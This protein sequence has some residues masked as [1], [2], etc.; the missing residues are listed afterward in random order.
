V[1]TI[2]QAEGIDHGTPK[3]YRQHIR[4]KVMP[5]CPPC[6]EAHTVQQG[7]GRPAVEKPVGA[8]L[9]AS[10]RELTPYERRRTARLLAARALSAADLRE[11]LDAVGVTAQDGR[12]ALPTPTT[13]STT[14]RSGDR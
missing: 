8:R 5:I 9:V 1:S 6:Q 11:L 13:T 7:E 2:G 4:R 3:G 10:V 12:A 14:T